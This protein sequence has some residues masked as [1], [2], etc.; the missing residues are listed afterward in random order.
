LFR[1]NKSSSKN[2]KGT[3]KGFPFYRKGSGLL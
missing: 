1:V 2:I 3:I